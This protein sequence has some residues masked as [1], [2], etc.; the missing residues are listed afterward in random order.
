MHFSGTLAN[1]AWCFEGKLTFD[2]L[3]PF[4]FDNAENMIRFFKL[5]TVFSILV[6]YQLNGQSLSFAPPLDVCQGSVSGVSALDVADLNNDGL[7]DVVVLEGGAHSEGRV[8]LAWFEQ[9]TTRKWIRHEFGDIE[10]FDDFIGS[11][12]CGDI[13]KDGYMD[14]VLSN[15]GHS[16]GPIKVYFFENPGNEKVTEKWPV[17]V[18]STIDGFHANDMRL[19]DIDTD[20]KIDVIIRHKNPESVKI[21][22][23]GSNEGWVTKTAYTGQAGEGLAVGDIDRD[24]LPDITISG[25]WLKTPKNPRTD[26]YTRYDIEAG[27]KLINKATK[28]ETGDINNDGRLDVVLSPAEHFKKYGGGNYDLAWY[29][30]PEDPESESKWKKHIV[31]SDIN[32]A[33]CVKLADFDNDGDLDILSAISWD[34]REIRIY[35]NE[36]GTFEKSMQVTSGK[37]IYSGAIADMDNDGDIDIV[38]ED[39]YSTNARPWFYENLLK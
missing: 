35:V 37:G 17:R 1:Y 3:I 28:E 24:G 30:C 31:R 25:H 22:F 20:G 27:Y 13:N 7:L 8:T 16:S 9:S 26:S 38:G 19:A 6:Q 23:Q 12:R 36:K 4:V 14:L 32:K 11:A 21:I 15:D 10:I 34:D 5:L 39:K 18:I 33:H 29:E 2:R